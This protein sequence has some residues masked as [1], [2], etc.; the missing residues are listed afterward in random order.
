MRRKR[1]DLTKSFSVISPEPAMRV[2]RVLLDLVPAAAASRRRLIPPSRARASWSSRR[3][4][5]AGVV[6][7]AHVAVGDDAE[8]SHVVVDDW[9]PEIGTGR[10]SRRPADR[11][12]GEMVIGSSIMPASDRF[13]TSTWCAWSSIERLRWMMPSPPCRCHRDGHEPR[14]RCPWGADQRDLHGDPLR[15]PGRGVDLGRDD[16]AL[17]RLQQDVVECRPSVERPGTGRVSWAAGRSRSAGSRSKGCGNGRP[18]RTGGD[19]MLT[20]PA[21]ASSGWSSRRSRRGV[22]S[23]AGDGNRSEAGS[24]AKPGRTCVEPERKGQRAPGVP[25]LLHELAEPTRPR[26]WA[27]GRRSRSSRCSPTMSALIRGAHHDDL[28]HP[29]GSRWTSWKAA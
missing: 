12:L 13:T 1:S 20:A 11:R 15:D 8:Q 19:H 3:R 10:T 2:D 24:H 6:L 5:A 23:P 18:F 28:L 27:P 29:R 14:S 25:R 22:A 21:P 26:C 17:A 16:I 4:P 7:K 9:T